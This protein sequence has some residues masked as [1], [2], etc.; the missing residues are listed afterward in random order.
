MGAARQHN[1]RRADRYV[2]SEEDYQSVSL[3]RM[4]GERQ[5]LDASLI[6][7]SSTGALIELKTRIDANVEEPFLLEFKVPTTDDVIVWKAKVA[8]VEWR[9]H[10]FR[11][12]LEFMNLPESF[13]SSLEYGLG[14]KLAEQKI[15]SFLAR[16]TGFFTS[17]LLRDLMIMV[18]VG[19]IL[20]AGFLHIANSREHTSN[21]FQFFKTFTPSK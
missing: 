2:L 4:T 9:P 15:D 12:G 3:V 7:L 8:R 13:A 1:R 17:K 20:A 16:L 21:K 6:N 5:L 18:L 10:H 14:P 19:S 11:L